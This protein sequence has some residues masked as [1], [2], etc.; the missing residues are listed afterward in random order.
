MAWEHGTNTGYSAH[1]CRC[2]PCRVAHREY[3]R[4]WSRARSR[5]AMGIEAPYVPY[6]DN[7]EA[8]EHLKWLASVGVGYK[9]VAHRIGIAP[10]T[11]LFIRQRKRT[12]SRASTISKILAVGKGDGEPGSLINAGPT[13]AL[14]DEM[15]AHRIPK[16]RIAR[17]I[18]QKG[19]GLQVSR[20]LVRR[21][22]AAAVAKAHAE[23]LAPV[24]E[25]RRMQR[26]RQLDYRRRLAAGEVVRRERKAAA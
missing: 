2:E 17:A 6:I 11:L 19:A 1:G 12:K 7:A 8:A 3:V 4:E 23:M 13:W 15:I 21:S 22:T 5:A 20:R 9:A 16:V 14:I 10:Q 26:E 18:G 24:L 25:E